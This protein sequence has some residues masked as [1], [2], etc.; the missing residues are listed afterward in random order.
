MTRKDETYRSIL[1]CALRLD[2]KKGHKRW[3]LTELSRATHVTRSLIY[4][5]F[6]KSKDGILV[7][8]VKMVGE[9]LFGLSPDRIALWDQSAIEESVCL[10]RQ[11]V[12]SSPHLVA[13][14]FAHR[15]E[16]NSIGEMLRDL[17]EAHRKKLK[18]FLCDISNEQANALSGLL[19]GLVIAPNVSRQAIRAF[20]GKLVAR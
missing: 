1:N 3:T 18:R 11:A 13:F 10:S 12:E 5:Y 14:F 15:N 19:L 8:A 20:L 7:A 2:F 17:E 6:G 16:D 9:E 4:Y